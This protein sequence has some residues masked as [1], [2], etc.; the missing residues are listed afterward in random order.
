V[1]FLHHPPLELG[2]W[3]EQLRRVMEE[4]HLTSSPAGG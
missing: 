3:E 2:N 4:V 1:D